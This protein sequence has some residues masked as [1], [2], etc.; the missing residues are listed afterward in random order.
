MGISCN[1]KKGSNNIENKKIL[2]FKVPVDKNGR[3]FFNVS[4]TAKWINTI[5]SLV[6]ENYT[7]IGMPESEVLSDDYENVKQIPVLS[8]EEFNKLLEKE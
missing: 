6:S 2:I 8:K 7:V 5:Q 3:A 4:D 1:G